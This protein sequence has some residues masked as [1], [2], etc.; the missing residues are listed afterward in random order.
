MSTSINFTL[1]SNIVLE[2]IDKIDSLQPSPSPSVVTE[3]YANEAFT[4]TPDNTNTWKI[5]NVFPV[6]EVGKLELMNTIH[7]QLEKVDENDNDVYDGYISKTGDAELFSFTDALKTNVG[8]AM[9]VNGTVHIFDNANY[10]VA[11]VAPII[12]NRKSLP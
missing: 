10:P 3:T 9:K 4:N 12:K 11:A 2:N 8:D 7:V 5:T 1:V 6:I